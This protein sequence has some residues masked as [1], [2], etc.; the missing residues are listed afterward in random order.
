MNLKCL[1]K[2]SKMIFHT[3]FHFILLISLISCTSI[4]KKSISTSESNLSATDPSPKIF[5]KKILSK[6][7]KT[8]TSFLDLIYKIQPDHKQKGYTIFKESL[9]EGYAY[10]TGPYDGLFI[11]FFLFIGNHSDFI[12]KQSSGYEPKPE[13]KKY[14]YKFEAYKILNHSIFIKDIDSVF[15]TLAINTLFTKQISKLKLFPKYV[16]DW[17]FYKLI[18]LPKKGTHSRL[19]VCKNKPDEPFSV[20]SECLQIGELVWTRKSFT[21]QPTGFK[22]SLETL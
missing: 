2:A 5:Q 22:V 9:N 7:S 17:E 13:L 20:T 21:V 12:I 19:L 6:N 10:G 4:Q 1:A 11:E 3:I 16:H 14:G 15:P 18:K 8:R